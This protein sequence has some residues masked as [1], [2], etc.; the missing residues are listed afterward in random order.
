MFDGKPVKWDYVIRLAPKLR[1]KHIII[2]PFKNISVRLAAQV[3][4]HSVASGIKM[5]IK[6][7]KMSQEA[8]TRLILWN[9]LIDFSMFSA[10]HL[11]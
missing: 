2:P 6:K 5:L 4:S 7:G 1:S 10:V 9:Y 11:N 8:S 3:L